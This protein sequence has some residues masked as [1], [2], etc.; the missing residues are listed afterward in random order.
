MESLR[1][2][3]LRALVHVQQ[4]VP[5]LLRAAVARERHEAVDHP[6][7]AA[8]LHLERHGERVSDATEYITLYTPSGVNNAL[9]DTIELHGMQ[10]SLFDKM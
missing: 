9:F 4:L 8:V 6:G 5:E 1:R 3:E 2:L 7:T 10:N